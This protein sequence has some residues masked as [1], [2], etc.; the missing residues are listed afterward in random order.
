M[1]ITYGGVDFNFI[2]HSYLENQ[3]KYDFPM[4]EDDRLSRLYFDF[5]SFTDLK[6]TQKQLDG[7][8]P[9]HLVEI[10]KNFHPALLRPSSVIKFNNEYIVWD[11]H[12][13][14]TIALCLGMNSAPC[15]IYECNSIDEINEIL[16]SDTVENIDLDQILTM[17]DHIPELK[18]EVI[19]RY[20]K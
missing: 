17:I 4:I 2:L 13:S 14:A 5:I 10:L 12:H 20:G 19:Q 8:K 7:F 18:D 9:D 16:D 15:M 11:G 3:K 6:I 1:Q